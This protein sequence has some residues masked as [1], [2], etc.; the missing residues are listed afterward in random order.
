MLLNRARISEGFTLIEVLVGVLIVAL[1][2]GGAAYFVPGILERARVNTAKT[3]LKKIDSAV[4][5][6]ETNVGELPQTLEDLVR[7]PADERIASEWSQV[8]KKVPVDPWNRKYIYRT[9]P[10]GANPYELYSEGNPKTKG[11]RI[12]VHKL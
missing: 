4:E 7:R 1:I 6:Y 8:L 11:P 2:F 10:G 12:D 3:D 5:I 9:T